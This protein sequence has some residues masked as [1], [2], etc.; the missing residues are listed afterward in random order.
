MGKLPDTFAGES[1]APQKITFRTPYTMSAQVTLEPS[2]PS[3]EFAPDVFTHSTDR[4]FEI[5][6]VIP[7]VYSVDGT[8]INIDL[9]QL[10]AEKL[11]GYVNVRIL[12]FGKAQ[13]LSKNITT[14][15]GM[16]KGPSELTWEW[17]QPYVLTR[18]EGLIVSLNSFPYPGSITKLRVVLAFQGN[19]LTLA[20]ASDRR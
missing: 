6:R 9:V 12:D 16:V 7:R 5:H 13:E 10:P 11:M 15:I 18:D 17:A 1:G 4:P 20:P 3:I 19:L 2:T 14:L 8:G